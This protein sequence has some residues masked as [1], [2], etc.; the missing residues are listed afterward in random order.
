MASAVS[1]AVAIWITLVMIVLLLATCRLALTWGKYTVL[2][3][4]RSEMSMIPQQVRDDHRLTRIDFWGQLLTTLT[5]VLGLALT[6]LYVY[7]AWTET[8]RRILQ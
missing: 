5:L 2:H 6:G 3:V 7:V 8:T 1:T 4:R